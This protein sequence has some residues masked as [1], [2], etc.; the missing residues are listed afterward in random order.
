MELTKRRSIQAVE[1]IKEINLRRL[2]E[3]PASPKTYYCSWND[4]FV[5]LNNLKQCTFPTREQFLLPSTVIDYSL[6]WVTSLEQQLDPA[7]LFR[8]VAECWSAI[9]ENPSIDPGTLAGAIA[10]LQTTATNGPLPQFRYCFPMYAHIDYPGTFTF[11]WNKFVEDEC[12]PRPAPTGTVYPCQRSHYDDS[13]KV[14]DCTT[15]WTTFAPVCVETR[16]Y[17]SWI[18]TQWLITRA[19]IYWFSST[20]ATIMSMAGASPAVV[21]AFSAEEAQG[22]RSDELNWFLF[23]IHVYSLLWLVFFILIPLYLIW[24]YLGGPL[25]VVVTYVLARDPKR[26]SC[27]TRCALYWFGCCTRTKQQKYRD[28]NLAKVSFKVLEDSFAV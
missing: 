24:A 19:P 21:N 6:Y 27:L 2:I 13:P 16:L 14:V 7:I 15:P 22:N 3:E 9:F 1:T 10:A 17:N 20:W 23:A 18:A 5:P 26:P 12:K 28:E 11:S 8:N 25:R 4:Q